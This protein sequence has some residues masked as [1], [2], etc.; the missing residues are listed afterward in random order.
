M[1]S[2]SICY[3]LKLIPQTKLLV[4]RL[5]IIKV[6]IN[7]WEKRLRLKP[8]FG[9]IFMQL[10]PLNFISDYCNQLF[11]VITFQGPINLR[12]IK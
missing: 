4:A 3:D 5:L 11:N 12:V 1:G 9:V 7:C 2:P 8:T 10:N 6:I